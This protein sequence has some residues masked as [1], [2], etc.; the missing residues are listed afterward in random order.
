MVVGFPSMAVG[1][2]YGEMGFP[3]Q[4]RT[5]YGVAWWQRGI[6]T[7][8]SGI[9]MGPGGIPTR[10]D[11]IPTEGRW[12]FGIPVVQLTGSLTVAVGTRWD[13]QVA[14]SCNESVSVPL[15]SHGIPTSA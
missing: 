2:P 15:H 12:E 6:P 3:L 14:C 5:T 11:G 8:M 7:R 9:P 1:F 13:S 4:L 10:P